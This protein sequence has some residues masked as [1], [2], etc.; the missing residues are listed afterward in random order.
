MCG[1]VV[2]EIS[3]AL[4]EISKIVSCDGRLYGADCGMLR[5]VNCSCKVEEDTRDLLDVFVSAGER[6][7]V[8]STGAC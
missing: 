4:F 8:G 7:A 5:I 6:G 1:Y 3:D 2:K